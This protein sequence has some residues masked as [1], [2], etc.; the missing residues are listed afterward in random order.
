MRSSIA[1]RTWLF[2]LLLGTV[3]GGGR[4]SADVA[5]VQTIDLPLLLDLPGDLAAVRYTPG[6]LD[7]S[8]AVQMRFEL[9]AKE[10]TKSGFGATAIVIYV[11]SPEDWKAAGIRTRYGFPHPMGLDAIAV[12]AWPEKEVVSYYRDLLGGELPLP[13]GTP[14]LA[15]PSEAAALSVV[16]LLTHLE[17]ARQLC[18]RAGFAGDQPWIAPLVWHLSARI[19]WDLFEP[20]RMPEIAE[21]LDRLAANRPAGA[22]LRLSDWREDLPLADRW[23]FDARFLRGADLMRMEKSPRS[24]WQMLARAL[25]GKKPLTEKLFVKEFPGFAAW[26]AEN[27]A[28]E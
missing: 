22:P 6:T 15:T 12:P 9:F 18:Q 28:P 8:A 17:V 21:T 14:L 26:K 3:A 16:D 2:L 23:W 20:G 1:R 11:L 7:R 25:E 27:F 5:G 13:R 24:L 10:F 4:L 19:A